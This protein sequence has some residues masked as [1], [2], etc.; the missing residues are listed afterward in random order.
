MIRGHP[1]D[2][3]LA[4]RFT[5]RVT[6][7]VKAIRLGPQDELLFAGGLQ[8]SDGLL[9]VSERGYMKRVPGGMVDAQRRA[10]KG[11][12]SFYFNKN[13]SN[14]S[15]IAAAAVLDVPRSFTVQTSLGQLVPLNSEE[16]AQ[17]KL[18]DR[19]KPYVMAVLDDVVTSLIL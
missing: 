16:I 9:L 17:Q 14:G 3:L 10:G 7:G 19:G 4:A 6:R 11:V 13:N 15:M 2:L 18:T 12:R 5:G 1:R 8:D